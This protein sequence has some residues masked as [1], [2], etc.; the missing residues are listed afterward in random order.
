VT[1]RRFIDTGTGQSAP[2]GAREAINKIID[3][4]DQLV[5]LHAVKGELNR[6]IALASVVAA[7]R[8]RDIP[9]GAINLHMVFSGPP[10]TG[11]TIV[12]RKVGEILKALK[13]LRRGH[14]VEV[15]RSQLVGGYQGHAAILTADKIKEALDGVLFID[16]AYTLSGSDPVRGGDSYGREAIDTLLKAMEDNRERLVV[17]AAGY[18]NEMR[19]FVDSNPG[20]K[21]RFSRFIEFESYNADDLFEI[22]SRVVRD[23]HYRI[24]PDAER[25]ARKHIA[26]MRQRADGTFGNARAVR[27][28][29]ERILPIQA[30]RVAYLPNFESLSD[31]ELLT[32]EAED[33]QRAAEMD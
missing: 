15:D 9:V 31:E 3:D 27:G 17:I 13:L 8:E 19:R 18:T 32:I 25:V 10:G 12:A 2:R 23:G 26:E 24:T 7:R 4:L 29:F 22:F 33:V 14:C 28:F 16:E 30:E 20:L 5:G 21:S 11:K 1:D 6:L